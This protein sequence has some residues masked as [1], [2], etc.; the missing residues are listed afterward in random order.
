MNGG[1]PS[2][3][4]VTGSMLDDLFTAFHLPNS[5]V[6]F[7]LFCL[8]YVFSK[9]VFHPWGRSIPQR[10]HLQNGNKNPWNESRQFQ[11][12]ACVK[13]VQADK[14]YFLFLITSSFYKPP[15]YLSLL[16]LADLLSFIQGWGHPIRTAPATPFLT[17]QY[18]CL[19]GRSNVSSCLYF[20]LMLRERSVN[21]FILLYF[22]VFFSPINM[23]W[24]AVILTRMNLPHSNR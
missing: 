9:P 14:A 10:P 13:A 2:P 22:L 20:S 23:S 12:G 5:V 24:R 21:R 18:G 19:S 1:L 8:L 17:A 4:W 6:R 15:V 16:S 7:A 11:I 3:R